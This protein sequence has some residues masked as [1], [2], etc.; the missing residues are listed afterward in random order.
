[1]KRLGIDL[2]TNVLDWEEFRDLQV[3]FLKSSISHIEIPTDHAIW[4]TLIRTAAAKGIRYI[5]SGINIVTEGIF[6]GLEAD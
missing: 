6:Q 4:A 2:Y 5:I 1:M 3:S